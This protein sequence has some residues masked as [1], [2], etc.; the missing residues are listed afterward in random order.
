LEKGSGAKMKPS[1]IGG[2]AV[3]EGVMMKNK[4]IYAVAVRKPDNEITVETNTHRDFAD[5]VKFFKLPIFR[6]MLAFVDSMII[7]VK[8]LN[9]SASFFDDED[10]GTQTSNKKK[11]KKSKEDD[12][13]IVEEVAAP[14]SDQ[15]EIAST[16]TDDN[17]KADKSN[18]L[19]MA[20]AVL[21]SIVMSVALFMVLPVLIT[22]LFA[23][24][25]ENHYVILFIEG[26]I[27]LAIFI[28]YVLLASRMNEIKR[29]FMYH[30][31]EH[32]TINCLENGFELTVE[33]VRWQ[34]KQHKRCGTSFMLLVVLISLVFFMFMPVD[35]LILKVLSRILLVPF[36]AGVSYEFIR[37]AGRSENKLVQVLSQPGLW[38][39]GLTTKEPD[40]SM[41]EVAIQS[42]SAVFDWKDF[43]KTSSEAQ[44]K[45]STAK[46][47]NT[48]QV[49]TKQAEAKKVEAKKV[50]AKQA[51]A[52]KA[53]A[54]KA[55]AKK[56]EARQA[57]AK[58]V[59]TKQVVAKHADTKSGIDKNTKVKSQPPVT[60]PV[61]KNSESNA[62][63]EVKPQVGGLAYTGKV[64]D[65]K[66][67]SIEVSKQEIPK[68]DVK[69]PQAETILDKQHE[70]HHNTIGRNMGMAPVNFRSNIK[71]QEDEEDDEIL[72]ALDKFFDDDKKNR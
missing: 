71:V 34:S 61:T 42:V 68:Q 13:F 6:G 2:M 24:F 10:E 63:T 30:G 25:I 23:R 26:I 22:N 72:K 37:L 41:I 56:A 60:K 16:K 5:K 31:A 8:V 65:D 57:E 40:D 53:E 58:K 47:N 70:E 67:A 55:E 3:M 43:V 20:F 48:K 52:K 21:I 32:K 46:G 50:E 33:N 38:M 39:Q 35:N 51:E 27:R 4:D 36:I 15:D 11:D 59:E 29:V 66:K 12:D 1:G 18:A 19:L 17:K 62:H 69:K 44:N 54:K 14:H 9:Y 64:P 45:K 49:T 28:G 7:G